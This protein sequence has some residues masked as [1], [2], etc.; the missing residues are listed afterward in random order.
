[1]TRDELDKLRTRLAVNANASTTASTVPDEGQVYLRL[2]RAGGHELRVSAHTYKGHEFVRI[3]PW[4]KGA[5]DAWWPV[6]GKG[7]T[8]KP[9]ELD[10]VATELCNVI[11]ERMRP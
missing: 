1:M 11:Y 10:A 9:A 8:L 6:T 3:A 4:Q 7:V 5:N 2:P